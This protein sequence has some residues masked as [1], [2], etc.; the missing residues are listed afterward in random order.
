MT[1]LWSHFYRSG[2][3]VAAP[4][5]CNEPCPKHPN[6]QECGDRRAVFTAFEAGNLGPTYLDF[7]V[8]LQNTGV[9]LK[10]KFIMNFRAGIIIL[11]RQIYHSWENCAHHC[12]QLQKQTSTTIEYKGRPC[13][14][15]KA[16]LRYQSPTN[17]ISNFLYHKVGGQSHALLF[18][19]RSQSWLQPRPDM[20][21]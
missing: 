1:V 12:P 8:E 13:I 15:W 17:L 19:R 6:D 9:R 2:D 3:L 21:L 10:F 16:I 7:D 11:N 14:R 18:C 4:G 20:F 5:Q